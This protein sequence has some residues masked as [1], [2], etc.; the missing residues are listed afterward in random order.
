VSPARIPREVKPR[1]SRT[2][3]SPA[4]VS[5]CRPSAARAGRSTLGVPLSVCRRYRIR[6]PS[7][8][9]RT[10]GGGGGGV[11]PLVWLHLTSARTGRCRLD[12]AD[13]L[14][15]EELIR[16]GARMARWNVP[17]NGGRR[18]APTATRTYSVDLAR[19]RVI[20][21]TQRGIETPG[22]GEGL[23]CMSGAR[24]SAHSS[25]TESPL[26]RPPRRCRSPTAG[27]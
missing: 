22:P 9:H 18:S 11:H 13:E 19:D 7:H 17:R 5:G 1:G 14:R 24:S 27:R 10:L 25:V 4:A 26:S 21:M 15:V 2:C 12:Q 23:S 8:L 20:R 6:P 3:S 16:V